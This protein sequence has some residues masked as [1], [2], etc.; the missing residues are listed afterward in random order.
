MNSYYS[1]WG[2]ARKNPCLD[3]ADYHLLVY[4]SLDVAAVGEQLLCPSK[5]SSRHLSYQLGVDPYWLQSWF[6]FCLLF[7]DLGKFCR[8]FQNLSPD[9]S[10]ELVPYFPQCVYKQRHDTLG[11]ILWQSVLSKKLKNVISP[12]YQKAFLGWLEIVCGHHGKP[13]QKGSYVIKS[14][15]LQ[16]DED[17][18]EL[19]IRETLKHWSIDFSPL[20][21]IDKKKF[22]NASWHLAGLAVLADWLGSDQSIFHYCNDKVSLQDYWKNIALPCALLAVEK[23]QLGERRAR[24]FTS[25]TQQFD[26][27]KESTPL[28]SYAQSAPINH[29][30]Q[31]F[32]LEDVT[33]AGKTEAAMVL[34]HRLMAANL[35]SGVYVGL[36]TMAT[37][38][39]MYQRM[40]RSYRFLYAEDERPPSLILAHGARHLSDEFSESVALSRQFSDQSYNSED[41]SAS[42]YCNEWFADNRKKALLAN[43]GVGTIDQ[44]LL[45][46]LPARHQSLRLLGLSHKV[47]LVDEVHAFDPYMRSLL[48]TL[49]KT[50]AEHGGSAILLS[51]TLPY[52]FR[53]ELTSAFSK[54]IG[55]DSSA[56]RVDAGYPWVSQVNQNGLSEKAVETRK[57]VER[58]VKVRRLASTEEALELVKGAVNRGLCVCW[59]RNTVKD[60]R[61]AYEQLQAKPWMEQEKLTLFHSRYA[62][63]DRQSIEMD[64]LKRF[65][66]LSTSKERLG[67]VLIATQVVEQSLDLDFDTMISDLAPID[68]LIQRAGRLQRH[69][70]TFSGDLLDDLKDQREIP[71]LSILSPDP[72]R[73]TDKEW[74][75]S[76]LPGTQAVYPNVGQLWL[77]IVALKDG[78]AMPKDAR[79]LIENV[80]SEEAQDNIP[81]ELE[82]ASF[83][84]EAK[85]R[86][87]SGMGKFNQLCLEKGYTSESAAQN[88][89]WDEEVRIP[90]RLGGDTVTVALVK[91]AGEKWVPYAGDIPYAWS[92]SQLSLPKNQW[93]KASRLIPS[94]IHDSLAKLKEDEPALRW[95][96][97]IPIVP[98]TDFLYCARAGWSGT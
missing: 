32:I 74:L 12:D 94:D 81:A 73:V 65:G 42:A 76:L 77:S 45:G 4:H 26:F 19:F 38:N 93:E 2:K 31:L 18:A 53:K 27:I 48:V 13:P 80:Y 59:I 67:Q 82:E 6:T 60:A 47:I 85:Q 64:V 33:G 75:K 30:Q 87:E 3:G 49:L 20:K 63:I 79:A 15:L 10:S 7:H 37:A 86:A 54:G 72:K 34:V 44:A 97:I 16:E 11:Y 52:S 78:F 68:L 91:S 28:Q 21:T 43:V 9:M 71:C 90:T 36:P 92:L 57:S 1:Y 56:S 70:R 29:S 55:I 17:A 24:P 25:I 58:E 50:H 8:S 41:L 89:G 83:E 66:K 22:K 40:S 88:G 84:A 69:I 61:D 23:A 39:A 95:V 98:E 35:A 46:I 62:M 5:W 96:E 14:D 51:A